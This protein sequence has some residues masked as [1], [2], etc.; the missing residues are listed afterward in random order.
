MRPP[1]PITI[2]RAVTVQDVCTISSLYPSK[3]LEEQEEMVRQHLAP[4]LG[5]QEQGKRTILLAKLGG[6][7]VGT[8]QV[9]WDSGD[10]AL[11]GPDTAIIHHLRTHPDLQ[12]QGIAT[13]L[14]GAAR[15]LATDRGVTNLTLGVEP[16]NHRARRIYAAWG[17]KEYVGYKGQDGEPII[18]MRM[19]LDGQ[20][21]A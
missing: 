11:S 6:Q 5:Q 12:G 17:F 9:V 18:A 3:S 4:E 21:P 16:D 8:A 14:F 10:P 19:A 1:L 2:V 13:H 15:E 7:V 20:D